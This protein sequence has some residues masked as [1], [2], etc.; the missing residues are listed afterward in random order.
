MDVQLY[1]EGQVGIYT[2]L[3][4]TST[5]GSSKVSVHLGTWKIGQAWI[6]P[7]SD[8]SFKSGMIFRFTGDNGGKYVPINEDYDGVEDFMQ[9]TLAK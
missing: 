9:K 6:I 2:K 3:L 7:T 4:E 5:N 8:S 1:K